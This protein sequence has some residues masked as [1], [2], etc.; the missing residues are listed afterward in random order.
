MSDVAGG[1]SQPVVHGS[2]SA[3]LLWLTIGVVLVTELLFFL[4]SLGRARRV[5]LNTHVNAG[6]IAALSVASVPEGAVDQRIRDE[7][8]DLSGADRISVEEP[9]QRTLML[10]RAEPIVPDFVID[11]RSESDLAGL[12]KA[13][14][15]LV[16]H[17]DNRV[18]V[19]ALSQLPRSAIV[20]VVVPEHSLVADLR[21]YA[22]NVAGLSM[23]IAGITG[24]L[25]YLVLL[26]L[27]VRPMQRLTNSIAA[28]RADPEFT[29]P[30]DPTRLTIAR[31]DEIAIAARELAA[32]QRELRAA[33]W[34]NARLAALGTAVAK[35]SHDLRAS[36]SAA[37][38][39]ADRLERHG[40]PT[41]R[42]ASGVIVTSIQRAVELVRRTLEFAREGPPPMVTSVFDLS[43]LVDE[44]TAVN[45]SVMPTTRV[46]NTIPSGIE[47]RA[48]REQLFRVLSNLLRNAAEAEARTVDISLAGAP[49]ETGI[50][51]IDIADS[52][53]GLP[54]LVRETLFR[55]FT[56][57][58]RP[59]G[60]GLGLAIARDLVRAHGG[61]IDLVRSC[62]TG[63][64]FRI[65]LPTTLRGAGAPTPVE[66]PDQRAVGR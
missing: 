35:V 14:V 44:T 13:L 49:N 5:W 62:A 11:L 54:N 3:R 24:V 9:G 32:M 42:R 25:I 58:G 60:T 51:T 8:L 40:D 6:H 21:R 65:S 18:L 30:I 41:V 50:V 56:V 47:I 46:D 12:R 59:G 26:G 37:M 2:L 33:L 39:Q 17:H 43:Q 23:I 20:Q 66:R 1:R 31:G 61:D 4:P 36:L 55:P 22:R 52:G 15:S 16:G 19:I 64:T 45:A 29:A 38:L 53:P 28:F 48:D 63:T 10:A 34:R 7:L 27:L 57:G